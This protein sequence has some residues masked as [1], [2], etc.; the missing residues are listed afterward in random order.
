[1]KEEEGEDLPMEES[2]SAEAAADS[3]EAP[4]REATD[5]LAT[6]DTLP[7]SPPNPWTR[8]FL[9]L[10]VVV[11]VGFYMLI[12]E[13][14]DVL[15]MDITWGVWLIPLAVLTALVVIRRLL[16]PPSAREIRFGQDSLTLP[17][18]RNSRRTEEVPYDEIRTIVPLVARG[19]PALVIDG[20]RRVQ[21]YLASDF[22]HPELWRVL[23]ARIM[24]QIGRRPNAFEQLHSMRDMAQL[25][26]ETT[27]AKAVFTKRLFWVIAIIYAAQFFLAPPVDVLQ[28]LY[29]GAN[30]PIMVLGEGQWWRLVTANLLHANALHFGVNAFA[31][32]FL[33]IY[34]ERIFG[35]AR[36]VVL[37]LGTALAG[38]AASL[39]GL[40]VLFSMGLST[41]IYGLLG[42]YLAVHL[43]FGK[44]LPPPY[45]QSR[46]WWIL[47]LGLN[48][49]LSVAVPIID[50]WGHFGGFFAGLLLAWVMTAGQ[51]TYRP[52]PAT[53]PV[54]HTA[55]ALLVALFV[56]VS[57]MT[58]GYA[59]GDQSEDEIAL[60]QGLLDRAEVDNPALLAQVARD[61]SRHSPR[62]PEVDPILV[63][64]AEA[65]FLRSD[66]IYVQWQAAVVLID[67]AEELGTPFDVE[68]MERGTLFFE[69]MARRHDDEQAYGVLHQLLA[70]YLAEIG[71][72][73]DVESPFESAELVN[74]RISLAPGGAIDEP[75]RV[76][77]LAI[78]D[79]L[80]YLLV[81]CYPAGQAAGVE[82]A[83]VEPDLSLGSV[84]LTLVRSAEEC[85]PD[86]A[87]AWRVMS[88][89]DPR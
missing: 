88:S 87:A 15:E 52:R 24:D 1:M 13:V 22:P 27:A 61:W 30:S 19:Q 76:Y 53:G 85:S 73:H 46:N 36:T 57:V 69:E 37:I 10:S 45:R 89:S 18:G 81:R 21:I 29:F 32:Y 35:T 62:P 6:G 67:L 40:E 65:A 58:V 71:P 55:A 49:G 54:V 59:I 78:D 14:F 66:D 56:V 77:V 75:R 31:L 51:K 33:G 20:P 2:P 12:R 9:I 72:F 8:G 50:A 84:W 60:A 26:Q 5:F 39:I 83:P 23:W 86:E 11:T 16:M 7:L 44:Q 34:C 64:L 80:R 43:R 17:R 3:P 38:A 42:A 47:I 25:T 74:G 79:N 68:L 82:A 41:A 48:A 28:Y 63:A 70:R 4:R